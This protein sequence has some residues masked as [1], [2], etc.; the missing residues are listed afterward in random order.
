MDRI[1]RLQG[2]CD[3]EQWIKFFIKAII[4]A[5]GDSLERIKNWLCIREKNLKKIEGSGKTVK[6]IKTVYDVIERYPIIDVNWKKKFN[7]LERLVKPFLSAIYNFPEVLKDF[8]AR[9][10]QERKQQK[11]HTQEMSK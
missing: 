2:V 6:A 5:A 10:W 7:D 1:K 9:H 11:P 8:I 4:F 3:Y